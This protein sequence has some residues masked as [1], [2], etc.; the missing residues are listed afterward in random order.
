MLSARPVITQTVLTVVPYIGL[1]GV[2][3]DSRQIG[4]AA[5]AA[6][7]CHHGPYEVL[8]QSDAYKNVATATSSGNK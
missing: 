3:P 1:N 4:L 2:D 6:L 8:M 7:V 5:R